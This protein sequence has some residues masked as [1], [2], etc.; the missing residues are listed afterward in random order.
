MKKYVLM[1]SQR[2]PAGHFRAGEETR[3]SSAIQEFKK[4]HTIRGNY[5]FWAKRF[6]EIAAGR[7]Y[8]SVRT[9][10]G[11]PYRSKQREIFRFDL[12]SGL[13]LQRIEKEGY[14]FMVDGFPTC[15]QWLAENDGLSKADFDDWHRKSSGAMALIHFT[16]FRYPTCL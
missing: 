13:G 3:F 16:E 15:R 12:R 7:A 4:I 10:S 8:L 9:W 1:V 14:S 5:E 11:L 6:T 2:F